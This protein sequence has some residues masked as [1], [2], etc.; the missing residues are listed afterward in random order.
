MAW[1]G[2]GTYVLPPAYS[3]EVNGTTIDA[4]R[5]NGLTSDVATG[6][7]AALAKNG[8][9][10]PT[11]NLPMGA[12][13]HTGAADASAAGQYSV[14]GQAISYKSVVVTDS[15][16]PANGM[17]LP[18]ANTLGLASNTTLRWSVNSTGNHTLA[19]PSTGATATINTASSS[20][21]AITST[22]TTG[23]YRFLQV[24]QTGGTGYIGLADS[25]G[26]NL[27]NGSAAYSMEF[28]SSKGFYF[29]ID[30][31]P[32]ALNIGVNGNVVI[33]APSSGQALAITG[34]GN[35]TMASITDGVRTNSFGSDSAR[36][37]VFYGASTNHG[38]DFYANGSFKLA[39]TS[40]GRFYGSAIHNNGGAV[41]GTTNQYFASGT[42]TPTLTNTTNISASTASKCQWMRVGNVVTVSGKVALTPTAS[43]TQT[44]LGI[45][46]PI[47]SNLAATEDCSGVATRASGGVSHSGAII[48][49]AANDR[50]VLD[51]Q[52]D[53]S[54]SSLT[55]Y[56]TFSYEV[57]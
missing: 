44:S 50:A 48:G 22:L 57:L 27:V 34:I 23:A 47:A 25:V 32:T 16:V 6:I 42:Y 11:A 14:Y 9:N 2:S 30:N 18:A 49:S 43:T 29:G 24:T 3:P 52:S 19:A 54:G 36:G 33:A 10:T 20:S 8:E 26:G 21:A 4:A 5:Y 37:T 45:S 51:M 15:T 17:Y 12:F 53:T 46:L 31:A 13:K 41:T 28:R 1:N 7:T 56:F 55:Y 35:A 40:D 39:L 38:V